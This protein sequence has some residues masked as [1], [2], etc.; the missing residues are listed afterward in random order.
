MHNA[1]LFWTGLLSLALVAPQNTA[2]FT[3][4]TVKLTATEYRGRQAIKVVED[5]S[6]PNGEAYAV[7][8]GSDFHDGTIDVQLAGRPIDGAAA[9]AR[10]FIGIAFR[11]HDGKFEYVYIR[12]TNGRADDQLRRN[13][14]TQYGEYPDF[15]FGRLRDEAPGV[16]ESYADMEPGV[17]TRF[18]LVVA[19]KSARLFLHGADQPCLVVNDMKLGD[20]TGAVALWIGPGT[21]GY[22]AD[23]KIQPGPSR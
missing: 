16:Y 22:F 14:S 8:N 23:L 12:P 19:G 15:G 2:Q 17:W 7:L 6:V 5:G 18:R 3:P 21:E 9:G 4:H 11:L 13:H 20:S 10:G 1:P